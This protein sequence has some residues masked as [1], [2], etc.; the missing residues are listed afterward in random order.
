MRLMIAL[1]LG[2]TLPEVLVPT[3]GCPQSGA[4]VFKARCAKCHGDTG[5]TEPAIARALKVRPLANDATL[6]GMTPAES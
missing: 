2:M 6:A 3:L 1:L 4:E 5:R